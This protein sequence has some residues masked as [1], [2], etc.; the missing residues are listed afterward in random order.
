[1]LHGRPRDTIDTMQLAG[2]V[3]G[4]MPGAR[5]LANVAE[6][7]LGVTV[8]KD[9]QTSDWSAAR[10]SE[11]QLRYAGAGRRARAP[12]RRDAVSGAWSPTPGRRSPRRTTRCRSSPGCAW[13]AS[14][15]TSRPISRRSPHGR[16]SR[17]RPARR[18]SPRPARTCRSRGRSGPP[19]CCAASR[20]SRRD[21]VIRWWPRTETGALSTS[22][23][24]LKRLAWCEW[25]RPLIAVAKADQRL[26]SFGRKLVAAINPVTG[27]L[28]GDLMPCGQKSGR[29]SCSSPNLLGLPPAARL[30]RGRAAGPGAGGRRPRRRSSCASPAPAERRPDHAPGLR[31]G[32]RPPRGDRERDDRRRRGRRDGGAAQGRQAGQLRQPVSARGRRACGPRPGPT[33]TSTSRSPR[34]RPPGRRCAPATPCCCTGSAG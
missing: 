27:R 30:R 21:D 11:Q 4:T 17:P 10:L 2:L 7:A 9:L 6:K 12:R 13:W 8:P 31:G 23:D 24:H 19:G 25:A 15:S 1:M 16:S 20:T 28:H 34:P 14:R 5:R 3:Y 18:S 26:S 33:T 29:T 32:P 22:A